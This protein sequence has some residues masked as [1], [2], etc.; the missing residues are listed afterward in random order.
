MSPLHI[1]CVV[2]DSFFVLHNTTAIEMFVDSSGFL[3]M[4]SGSGLSDLQFHP[5]YTSCNE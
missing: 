3:F 2:I 4:L 1:I 5:Q